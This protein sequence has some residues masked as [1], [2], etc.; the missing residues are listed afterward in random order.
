LKVIHLVHD[1]LKKFDFESPR[2]GVAGLN[3]HASDG[4]LF[5]LEEEQEII[6]AIEAAKSEGL[7]VEG[8]LPPDIL[9]PK[10]RGGCYDGCVA[11]YHDQGHIAFKFDG[12][13]WSCETGSMASVK[14]VNITLG[15]PII[16]VSVDHGTAFEIAGLGIASPDSMVMAIEYAVKM[17]G[18]RME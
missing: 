16:R 3:P 6:P 10:A 4:G 12:F 14:G 7:S 11:M 15:I 8:P 5:G 2:I 18:G 9:F 1:A 17:V 13:T